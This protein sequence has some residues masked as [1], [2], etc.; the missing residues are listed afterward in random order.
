MNVDFS[1][2]IKRFWSEAWKDW[3][4]W[5][6]SC[7]DMRRWMRKG[8]MLCEELASDIN[9][10]F[11]KIKVFHKVTILWWGLKTLQWKKCGFDYHGVFLRQVV[12]IIVTKWMAILLMVVKPL[13]G[14]AYHVCPFNAD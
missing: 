7:L 11:S 12:K 5:Y 1:T 4:G 14:F 8:F 13:N 10:E 9:W 3:S 6:W 2:E